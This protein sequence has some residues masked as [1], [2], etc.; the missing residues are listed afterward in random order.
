MQQMAKRQ[1]E[2]EQR[3]EISFQERLE[4]IKKRILDP[5]QMRK[6]EQAAAPGVDV[7]RYAV[8]LFRACGQN[9]K[10]C[11]S[12]IASLATAL[13]ESVS[14]ALPIGGTLGY[15]YCVPYRGQ[16]KFLAGYQGLLKLAYNDGRA[17]TAAAEVVR[18]D[19]RFNYA[20]GNEPY[21]RHERNC[22]PDDE[23]TYAWACISVV[24]G[25]PF[26]DVWPASFLTAHAKKYVPQDRS[27]NYYSDSL[28]VTNYEM[29]CRKTMLRRTLKL[30]PMSEIARDVVQREE[31]IEEGIDPDA[32][33]KMTSGD[34]QETET[35][36]ELMT[37]PPPF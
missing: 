7:E 16:A 20:L 15:G 28:I 6:F 24:A 33:P 3:G 37:D 27:G 11:N 12:D 34:A 10:V 32:E 5:D 26:V 36:R 17:T 30:M 8:H 29:W 19:D 35:L 18:K 25:P 21:V 13:L 2:Q 4:A 31:Y 1:A 14:L 9:M 23:I 22:Q